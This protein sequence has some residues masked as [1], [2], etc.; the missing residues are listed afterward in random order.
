MNRAAP[1]PAPPLRAL[2]LLL[3]L[4]CLCS[5]LVQSTGR[6]EG[7]ANPLEAACPRQWP[8]LELFLPLSLH[9]DYW[10]HYFF[11]SLFLFWPLEESKTKLT[12]V[13][14]IESKTHRAFAAFKEFLTEHNNRVEGGI[15]LRLHEPSIYYADKGYDRQQYVMFY[16]ENF[17]SSEYVGFVDSDAM[18]FTYVGLTDLFEEGKPVIHGRSGPFGSNEDPLYV[19]LWQTMTRLTWE[20]TGLLEPTRCM[21]YF[22]FVIRSQHLIALRAYLEER[23]HMPFYEIFLKRFA[24]KHYSQFNVM[25][26]FLWHFHRDSY[27]W[28]IHELLPD[29]DY[30]NPPAWPGQ[31]TNVSVFTK[32]MKYPKPR[33]AMHAKYREKAEEILGNPALLQDTLAFGLC[34]SPPL[35]RTDLPFCKLFRD[36]ENVLLDDYFKFETMNWNHVV[37]LAQRLAAQKRRYKEIANCSLDG[38]DL[39]AWRARTEVLGIEEGGVYYTKATGRALFLYTNGTL[40]RL[41]DWTTVL[42]MNLPDAKGITHRLFTLIPEGPTMPS[43]A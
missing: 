10:K 6:E 21:A 12:V 16:P 29:W 37:P 8:D 28:Y 1:P 2:L 40:R 27:R 30:I 33:V 5:H 41:P 20:I 32:E 7:G 11:P 14:D 38:P 23:F 34:L 39:G 4:L 31:E 42:K 25:C 22:P 26:T 17:T 24:G 13:V 43:L 3:P 18:F 19:M 15:S 9:N 36:N 35:P